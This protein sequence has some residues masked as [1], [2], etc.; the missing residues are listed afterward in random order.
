LEGSQRLP[1][2][3]PFIVSP[4]A[5]ATPALAAGTTAG[6]TWE[7]FQMKKRNPRERDYRKSYS[8]AE[9][10]VR[11]G[12]GSS[13]IYDQIRSGKLKAHRPGGEGPLRIL[14]SDEEAWI[15]GEVDAGEAA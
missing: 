11:H 4:A 6:I 2:T 14:A 5:G 13:F 3:A 8:V 7:T 9:I 10:A 1:S 15:R 12:M